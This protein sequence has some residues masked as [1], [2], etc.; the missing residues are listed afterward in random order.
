MKRFVPVILIH[1]NY[2][3]ESMVGEC[4]RHLPY[5]EP[6][7]KFY[8]KPHP[9]LLVKGFVKIIT[10]LRRTPA[11]VCQD[12]VVSSGHSFGSW[13]IVS[14]AGPRH[15][16]NVSVSQEVFMAPIAVLL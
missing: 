9:R 8:R 1:D 15:K 2:Q 5:I 16:G 6:E 7:A 12:G 4:C 14:N 11:S 10:S 3:S 13:P